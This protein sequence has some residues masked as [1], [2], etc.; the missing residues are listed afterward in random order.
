VAADLQVR[1]RSRVGLPAARTRVMVGTRPFFV[2][3]TRSPDRT[4]RK[5]LSARRA[6]RRPRSGRV[7]PLRWNA[8]QQ[9]DLLPRTSDLRPGPRL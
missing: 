5:A 1:R 6:C 2:Q 3:A 9:S 7:G 8:H 4:R